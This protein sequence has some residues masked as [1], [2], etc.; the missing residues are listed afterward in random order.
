VDYTADVV[1]P[2]HLQG[3]AAVT[4]LASAASLADVRI[5]LPESLVLHNLQLRVQSDPCRS[6]K[7]T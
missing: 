7:L 6:S 1:T 5:I 2:T 3:E 4:R